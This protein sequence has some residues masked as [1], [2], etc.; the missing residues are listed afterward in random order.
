MDAN[1][2]CWRPTRA[3]R[4]QSLLSGVI[5]AVRY[6][7]KKHPNYAKVADAETLIVLKKTAPS[8]FPEVSG[9]DRILAA[10]AD[11][12][13]RWRR[14]ISKRFG[15]NALRSIAIPTSR[16]RAGC[17]SAIFSVPTTKMST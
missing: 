11:V 15:T 3:A 14:S 2:Q 6:F 9:T 16:A 1:A 13:I 7:L 5:W 12:R 8:A 17:R 4:S 10:T